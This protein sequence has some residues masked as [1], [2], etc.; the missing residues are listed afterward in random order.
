MTD[1]GTI[2]QAEPIGSVDLWDEGWEKSSGVGRLEDAKSFQPVPG[3][4]KLH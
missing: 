1:S 2:V 3:E 4:N